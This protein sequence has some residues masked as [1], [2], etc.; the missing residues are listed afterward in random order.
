MTT[1]NPPVARLQLGQLLRELREAARR[2]RHEA[3]EELECQHP[4]ISK[5]ET[6]KATIGPGD[7]RLLLKLYDTD[8]GTADTAVQLARQ[9]RKRTRQRVPDW[10]RRFVALESISDDIRT[11]EAEL[12]PGLMQTEDYARAVTRAADPTRQ[13]DEVERLVT[14][15]N[16]RQYRFS[17]ED[18]PQLSVVINEAVIRR[19]VGGSETMREQLKHLR[20]LANRPQVTLQ[21]LPFTA[22]AHVAMGSSFHLLHF[23]NPVGARVVYL[24]DLISSDYLDGE[25][26]IDWY[27][28][29]FDRLRESALDERKTARVIDRARREL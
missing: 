3:A 24:D 12:V 6:G 13:P 27:D 9:A 4:K 5:I 19:S 26:Q 7:V 17:E 20:E 8:D 23:A 16:E 21:V 11:Y 29:A 18:E 1:S 14:A 25:A 28:A 22:G 10:A 15:R 2:T